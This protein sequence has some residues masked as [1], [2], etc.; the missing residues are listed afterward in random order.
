MTT[1]RT[2]FTSADLP[3]PPMRTYRAEY[4]TAQLIDRLCKLP[5]TPDAM[6]QVGR[7]AVLTAALED[8]RFI[9]AEGII[10]ETL[11]KTY[12]RLI[13]GPDKP[14]GVV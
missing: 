11:P 8:R 3:R 2:V 7:W 13:L 12:R 6:I 1:T 5:A 4:F 14:F 9:E 10:S